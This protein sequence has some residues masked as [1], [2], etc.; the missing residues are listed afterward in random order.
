MFCFWCTADQ[1]AL[2]EGAYDHSVVVLVH[3]KELLVNHPREVLHV[4]TGVYSD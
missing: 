2:V 1:E 3:V 4:S